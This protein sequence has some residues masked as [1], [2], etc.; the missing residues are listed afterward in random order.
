M[1]EP[2]IDLFLLTRDHSALSPDVANGINA[3]RG[4]KLKVHRQV[5][6]HFA[7]DAH[8]LQTISRARNAAKRLGTAGFAMFLDDDVVLA[9]TSVRRLYDRL[10]ANP[11]YGAMAADYLNESSGGMPT[12]HVGMGATLF[13][14]SVLNRIQFRWEPGRCECQCCCDDLRAQ[15]LGIAYVPQVTARHIRIES[16][17]TSVQ[18][19]HCTAKCDVQPQHSVESLPGHILVAFDR[20][21]FDKFRNQFL[22]SLRAAGNV[23]QVTVV[24]Y[25]LYPS[26][27]RILAMLPSVDV[28]SLPVNGIL[29]PVRR[30]IDFQRVVSSQP[31][32][33]PVAYWDAGDV[34]IQGRLEELWK[35]V[36]AN[37][38]R[39][40]AVREPKSHPHNRA[41]THWTKSI[42]DPSARSIAYNLL[43][44]RP[45]LNS[46][47][48]AGTAKA[49]FRYL[50]EADRLLHSTA[51]QG[52]S[53]WG[54]QTALNLYCHSNPDAWIET[55]QRW[56]YCVH[57]RG[58]G[59][60]RIQPDGTITNSNHTPIIAVHGNALS[61]RQFAIRRQFP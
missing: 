16:S 19:E 24:G 55:D 54:D 1:S 46:G 27:Q 7:T 52:T 56:N 6:I 34:V 15:H 5:G 33:T 17:P 35:E 41:V 22:R 8:R 10:R 36:R 40:L 13:R 47:F 23:E 32:H 58:K 25:G 43:T 3:Q 45:F 30:L 28:V 48:A 53:D 38:G 26:E 61:L 18:Q 57:D 11:A 20:R 49:M 39:V 59:D 60:V 9:P 12:K 50:C 31:D 44:T 4:V 21:H 42:R 2:V 51:L 37:S 29:P 14:R